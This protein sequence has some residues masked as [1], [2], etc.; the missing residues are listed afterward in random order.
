MSKLEIFVLGLR[1]SNFEIL[2]FKISNFTNLPKSKFYK[3]HQILP[4]KF[5]IS[6]ILWVLGSG[7]DCGKMIAAENIRM[8][9]A[10]LQGQNAAEGVEEG[11]NKV[12]RIFFGNFG[13]GEPIL[14]NF[15]KFGPYRLQNFEKVLS[16]V[17]AHI[18]TNF[19]KFWISNFVKIAKL[20]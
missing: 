8:D 4:Q 17:C 11:E 13:D 2:G 9:Y 6:Q 12:L 19:G 7:A 5:L 1:I 16:R 10:L 20:W 15:A 3:N 18:R 14:W